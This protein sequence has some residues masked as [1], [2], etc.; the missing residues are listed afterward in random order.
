[1]AG[2]EPLEWER[3]AG[4]FAAG[5]ALGYALL[6]VGG[7]VYT[8]TSLSKQPKNE[9]Q[10]LEVI[11][12]DEHIWLTGRVL[13]G[14]ALLMMAI[15]L[16]Y[17]YRVVEHRRPEVPSYGLVLAIVGPLLLA[18]A[19]V[20]LAL[21]QIDSAHEF[22]RAEE[23]TAEQAEDLL[24]ERSGMTIGIGAAGAL[25]LALSLVLIGMAAMRAGVLSRFMGILGIIVGSLYVL[26]ELLPIGGPGFIQ[27]FWLGAL[28]ALFLDKWPGGRGP[29]WETGEA[30]PWPSA[31][32]R[33]REGASAAGPEAGGEVDSPAPV[34][35]E[36][37]GQGPDSKKRKRKRRR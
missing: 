25:S 10:L 34:T 11:N 16:Y 24:R 9:R 18:V 13:Q 3:R 22:A 29:A 20:L 5:A 17:L 6:T 12:S 14:V 19:G 2:H 37:S 4:R 23:R 36:V 7:G 33:R 26:G 8:S 28:A 30:I 21:D 31:A 15:V 35:G 32:D 1:V 27:L